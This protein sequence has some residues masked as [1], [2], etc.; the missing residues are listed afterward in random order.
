[1]DI[2]QR[3][4]DPVVTAMKLTGGF[5]LSQLAEIS[6]VE[7][8]TIQNWVKRGWI[9]APQNRRYG[10]ESVARVLVINKLKGAMQ[11][12]NIVSLLSYVNGKVED[13]SDDAVSDG[14]LYNILCAVTQTIRQN[15]CISRQAV[16][17][18][19]ENAIVGYEEPFPGG[20]QKLFN[21]LRIMVWACISTDLKNKADVLLG[22]CL[23]CG[24]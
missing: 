5:T 11:L 24:S 20:K 16:E 15:D 23:G 4:F 22:E 13:R 8:T 9:Q 18:T 7:S 1:M 2:P 17:E 3:A 21:T 12:S 10:E 19:I 14:E 6:G